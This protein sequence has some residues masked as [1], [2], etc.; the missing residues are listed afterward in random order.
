MKRAN[1]KIGREDI[2]A[3]AYAQCRSNKG[4]PGVD[5]QDFA[6]RR[7]RNHGG[8]RAAGGLRRGTLAARR[9]RTCLHGNVH[10]SERIKIPPVLRRIDSDVGDSCFWLASIR[11]RRTD[12]N[13][14]STRKD[15]FAATAGHERSCN[16]GPGCMLIGP[17]IFGRKKY[18]PTNC[19]RCICGGNGRLSC[20]EPV[21]PIFC[22]SQLFPPVDLDRP[23]LGALSLLYESRV[24]ERGWAD[25]GS[26]RLEWKFTRGDPRQRWPHRRAEVGRA[27]IVSVALLGSS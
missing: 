2:L 4:A 12:R 18:D 14:C 16:L 13:G 25:A 7:C 15:Q 10:D 23:S 5:G 19:H 27:L 21:F 1:D 26:H 24:L 22:G 20:I 11:S 6:D 17:T 9:V 3:H 8:S